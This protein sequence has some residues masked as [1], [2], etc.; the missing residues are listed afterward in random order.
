MRVSESALIGAAAVS[1]FAPNAIGARQMTSASAR[2]LGSAFV[3]AGA[4]ENSTDV[5]RYPLFIANS[6]ISL[7]G[8][9]RGS[10]E[11]LGLRD[12]FHDFETERIPAPNP[13]V[14]RDGCI[15]V[16]ERRDPMRKVLRTSASLTLA[17]HIAHLRK[18]GNTVT[19]LKKTYR[20]NLRTHRAAVL[21]NIQRGS[22]VVLV[23]ECRPCLIA[24]RCVKGSALLVV[25]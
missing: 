5:L 21:V 14:L 7:L 18:I 2:A 4:A 15:D 25:A 13:R 24:L 12:E 20:L 10:G 8:C 22:R 11:N 19:A 6:S 23:P 3:D 9:G 17:F 16:L 1:A